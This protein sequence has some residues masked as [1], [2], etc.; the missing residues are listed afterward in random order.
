[1]PTRSSR[2]PSTSLPASTPLYSAVDSEFKGRV[3][4]VLSLF[5]FQNDFQEIELRE[6]SDLHTH[7]AVRIAGQT[8]RHREH[9]ERPEN[10]FPIFDSLSQLI[11]PK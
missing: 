7:R 2:Y 10:A 4:V 9:F 11:V 1:M 3:P 8:M 5:L 6:A